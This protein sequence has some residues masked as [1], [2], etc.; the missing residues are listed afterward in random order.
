[1]TSS[2]SKP[3][4]YDQHH[5]VYNQKAVSHTYDQP[6]SLYDQIKTKSYNQPKVVDHHGSYNPTVVS[7]TYDQPKIETYAKLPVAAIHEEYPHQLPHTYEHSK[8]ETYSQTSPEVK[9][10]EAIIKMPKHQSLFNRFTL[11]IQF[12]HL[13]VNQNQ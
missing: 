5:E 4:M 11:N 1:M 10:Q 7:K 2:Y 13:L 3:K 6:E 9:H 8:V 12:H